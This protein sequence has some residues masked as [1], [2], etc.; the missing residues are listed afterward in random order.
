MGSNIPHGDDNLED[1]SVPVTEDKRYISAREQVIKAVDTLRKTKRTE[2]YYG[3]I[4]RHIKPES[5]G[6]LADVLRELAYE[7]VLT[8]DPNRPAPSVISWK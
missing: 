8:W 7:G 1:S 3:T 6:Y 4:A 5:G 2:A